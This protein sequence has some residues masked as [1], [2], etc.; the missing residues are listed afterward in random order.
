MADEKIEGR[1]QKLAISLAFLMLTTMFGCVKNIQKPSE[2]FNSKININSATETPIPNLTDFEWTAVCIVPQYNSLEDLRKKYPFF[3][4]PEESG[5]KLSLEDEKYIEQKKP[6]LL[7]FNEK[8]NQYTPV[9][10]LDDSVRNGMGWYLEV[11]SSKVRRSNYLDLL[12]DSKFIQNECLQY[13]D[14]PVIKFVAITGSTTD[15]NKT[16]KYLIMSKGN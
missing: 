1:G 9:K 13:K 14:S 16:F 7:F 12:P 6:F 15:I 3:K 10:I 5:F 2:L 8:L 11:E 4:R